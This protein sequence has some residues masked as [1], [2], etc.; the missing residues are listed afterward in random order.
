MSDSHRDAMSALD[1]LEGRLGQTVEQAQSQIDE[2]AASNRPAA[3]ANSDD[4]FLAQVRAAQDRQGWQS[5]PVD[6][7][8]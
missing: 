4:G 8:M 7:G 1:R 5:I 6:G 3:Q 2:S